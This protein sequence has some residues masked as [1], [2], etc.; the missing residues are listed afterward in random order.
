[1]PTA[2]IH[3]MHE[4]SEG[5]CLIGT[6]VTHLSPTAAAAVPGLA[7]IFAGPGGNLEWTA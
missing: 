3:P 2:T 6:G 4:V 1:M 5:S 7:L